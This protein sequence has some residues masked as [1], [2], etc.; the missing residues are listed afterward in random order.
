MSKSGPLR[1][2]HGGGAVLGPRCNQVQ[3]KSGFLSSPISLGRTCHLDGW[4][5]MW[6]KKEPKEDSSLGTKTEAVLPSRAGPVSAGL[7]MEG[8]LLASLKCARS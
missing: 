3:L 7:F 8:I 2:F 5:R 6:F 1:G 4:V